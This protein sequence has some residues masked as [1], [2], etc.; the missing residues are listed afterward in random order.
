MLETKDLIL[1]IGEFEDWKDMYN[2]LWRHKESAKYMLW[3]PLGSEEEAKRRMRKS[4][5]Y[6]Q[7]NKFHYFVYEKKSNQAIGFAGMSEVDP[8]VY[9]DTGIAIGPAFVGQGYGK[10]ILSALVK[11][12]FEQLGAVK[13]ICSCREQNIASKRLQQSLGFEYS[14]SVEKTDPRTGENY[15]LEYYELSLNEYK[16]KRIKIDK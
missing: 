16:A 9:E 13:F 14:H 11:C 4:I 15:I 6:Q 3:T 8:N 1:N 2:N 5:D 10:Q 12:T 7:R